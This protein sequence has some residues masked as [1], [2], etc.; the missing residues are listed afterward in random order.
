[1]ADVGEEPVFDLVELD[2]LFV[3]LLEHLAVFLQL[4]TESKFAKAQGD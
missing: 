2:E 4:V 1:M 3:G